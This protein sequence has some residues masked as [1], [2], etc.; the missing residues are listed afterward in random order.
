M[1]Y[2]PRSSMT[3]LLTTFAV[4]CAATDS[5]ASDAF[6]SRPRAILAAARFWRECLG[7]IQYELLSIWRELGRCRPRATKC[8]THLGPIYVIAPSVG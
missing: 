1:S 5:Q 4:P 7:C 2:A 8:L 6:I 3:R